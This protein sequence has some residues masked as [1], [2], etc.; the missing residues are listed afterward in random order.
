MCN[1]RM[2][3]I[4]I[5]VLSGIA[6]FQAAPARGVSI[7]RDALVAQPD[8]RKPLGRRSKTLLDRLLKVAL[9]KK[10]MAETF[11]LVVLLWAVFAAVTYVWFLPIQQK[12]DFLPRWYGARA[13][14][15]G[16]NPYTLLVTADTLEGKMLLHVG[17][18]RYPATITYTLLPFW[19]LPFDTA[20][21]LWCGLQLVFFS[22]LPL[23]IY[24]TLS[25]QPTPLYVALII[26]L[27]AVGF[28]YSLNVY[29]L[30]QFTGLALASLVLAW[31]GIS[32]R[33]HLVTALSLVLATTR[34]E[35]AIISAAVLAFLLTRRQFAVLI[36]WFAV[37][38]GVFLL[39]L[40]Q[41]G[42]W[43]PDFLKQVREYEDLGGGTFWPPQLF[44][45]GVVELV[46]V[47]GVLLWGGWLFRQMLT[48]CDP[49]LQ[50]LWGLSVIIVLALLL[51]PQT[52]DYTM[53]YLLLPIWLLLWHGRNSLTA[54]VLFLW[55]PVMSYAVKY[56][57]A[58]S[59]QQAETILWFNE[60]MTPL[61][62]G[63]LLTYEWS[64]F[65]KSSDRR[66]GFVLASV[67]RGTAILQASPAR[68]VSIR[69]HTLVSRPNRQSAQIY[70]GKSPLERLTMCLESVGVGQTAVS[71]RLRYDAHAR[72]GR[73][74][75]VGLRYSIVGVIVIMMFGLVLRTWNLGG[76][77]LWSDEALTALRAHAPLQ[78]SLASIVAPATRPRSTSGRCGCYQHRRRQCCGC[79]RRYWGCWE[80]P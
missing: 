26:L 14:L 49:D 45:A 50:L 27:S 58:S 72:F 57:Y 53:V 17:A 61:A 69:C 70:R 10:Q 43:V 28:P 75:T 24:R 21:S 33:N 20:S 71:R 68:A 37:M 66:L 76:A 25:W 32:K 55:L 30:G 7:L 48:R 5:A 59:G 6:A 35:G 34:P 67:V 22:L 42:W 79:R 39:S 65:V 60:V 23:L 78:E 9:A 19:L 38:A 41:I 29:T 51:L 31:W 8:R 56:G 2:G 18:F 63:A 11:L 80:S 40:L 1:K 4:L 77:S 74:P 36:I 15:R 12:S 54:P 73:A 3:V 62:I 47:A 64:C 16:T 13:V 46:F 52:N 44:G